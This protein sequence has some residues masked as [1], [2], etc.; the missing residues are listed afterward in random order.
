[1]NESILIVEDNTDILNFLSEALVL[2]GYRV[3]SAFNGID[4][5]EKAL[6]LKPDLVLMDYQLPVMDGTT[7]MKKIK[8]CCPQI[9][10]AVITACSAVSDENIFLKQGFDG[11]LKK[12]VS[13][14]DFNTWIRKLLT[15]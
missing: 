15:D 12:P 6:G 11:Y 3:Y 9:K 13:L 7:S 2:S 14:A 4:G 5:Y 8:E 10:V 1:M